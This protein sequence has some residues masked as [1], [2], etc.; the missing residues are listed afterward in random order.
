MIRETFASSIEAATDTLKKLGYSEGQALQTAQMFR[1]HDEALLLKSI[2]HM[3][4]FSEL[5]NL[6]KQGRLELE[7]LFEAD[8]KN[9]VAA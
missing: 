3:D 8:S 4:D 5:Q 2:V 6:T 9:P 1:K 7:K